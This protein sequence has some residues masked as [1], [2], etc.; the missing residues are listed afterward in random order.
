MI[1][2]LSRLSMGLVDQVWRVTLFVF[3]RKGCLVTKF[4]VRF[5]SL[6][7][8]LNTK[9]RIDELLLFHAMQL[10][11]ISKCDPSPIPKENQMS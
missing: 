9:K 5:P 3:Q 8:D 10:K 11:P 1:L 4:F 7:L 2:S 6:K